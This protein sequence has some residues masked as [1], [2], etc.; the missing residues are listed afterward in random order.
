MKNSK[1]ASSS[2][3]CVEI[4]GKKVDIILSEEKSPQEK[5]KEAQ[6]NMKAFDNYMMELQKA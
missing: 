3:V 4:N 5:W 1:R 6:A 2:R